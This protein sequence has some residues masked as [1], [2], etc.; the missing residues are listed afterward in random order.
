VRRKTSGDVS[1]VRDAGF[2]EQVHRNVRDLA[3]TIAALSWLL[4][5]RLPAGVAFVLFV[6]CAP[7]ALFEHWQVRRIE[8]RASKQITTDK[9]E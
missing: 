7:I 8:R 3:G 1:D 4:A 6:I 9:A 2:T 5:W